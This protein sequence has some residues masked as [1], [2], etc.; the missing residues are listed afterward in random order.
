MRLL[1]L[2]NFKRKKNDIDSLLKKIFNELELALFAEFKK[3]IYLW[4]KTNSIKH[5]E[6]FVLAKFLIKHSFSVLHNDIDK[7]IINNFAK[8]VEEVFAQLHDEKYSDILDYQGMK[9]TVDQKCDLFYSLRKENKPPLCWHLIYSAFTGKNTIS[10]IQKE[11]IG[12]NTAIKSLKSKV[13]SKELITKFEEY[14]YYKTQ[15]IES[16]DLA[17]ITFRQNIRF[18]KKQLSSFDIPNQLSTKK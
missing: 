12:L 18:A 17:E 1:S 6:C 4:K 15:V 7:N 2:F 5:Y 11:V 8:S 3:D 9:S 13:G 14:I 16:F 10:N